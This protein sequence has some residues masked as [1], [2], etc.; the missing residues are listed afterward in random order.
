[1]CATGARELGS[2]IFSRNKLDV[3]FSSLLRLNLFESKERL[4]QIPYSRRLVES[5]LTPNECVAL[6]RGEDK[7]KVVIFN[8]FNTPLDCGR[9]M[10]NAHK[11]WHNWQLFNI[12]KNHIWRKKK[13]E[14]YN[15]TRVTISWRWMEWATLG[16]CEHCMLCASPQTVPLLWYTRVSQKC[17]FDWHLKFMRCNV[18][19]IENARHWAYEWKTNTNNKR[20]QRQHIHSNRFEKGFPFAV[21]HYNAAGRR[22][23]CA[24]TAL[25]LHLHSPT[26]IEKH[27]KNEIEREWYK[28]YGDAAKVTVANNS[29]I[30]AW[31]GCM[32]RSAVWRISHVKCTS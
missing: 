21:A 4:N 17:C 22:D 23:K 2:D 20:Q 8:I 27:D 11:S 1:M 5:D 9:S 25:A 32:F 10:H 28:I 29:F 16:I 14:Y 18:I 26:F 12:H 7:R 24:D 15:W 6:Q 19:L 3:F 31:D 13:R 30:F